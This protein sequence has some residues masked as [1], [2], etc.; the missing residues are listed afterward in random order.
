MSH[1]VSRR[2]YVGSRSAVRSV[3]PK[4]K[5]GHLVGSAEIVVFLVAS[6]ARCND[7]CWHLSCLGELLTRQ[8]VHILCGIEARS[9]SHCCS[10]RA[11][12]I[13][14]SESLFLALGIWNAMQM[15]HIAICGL[16]GCTVFF[17]II[18]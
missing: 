2:K 7:Y 1:V 13:T 5:C 8:E 11:I 9:C 17:H 4:L 10:G 6:V 18:S 15:R 12:R 3:F 14:Y 16:S